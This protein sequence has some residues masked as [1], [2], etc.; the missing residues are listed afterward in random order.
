MT[1]SSYAQNYED[2]MLWRALNNVNNGFYVDLGSYDPIEHS[3]TKAF[4]DQGWNGINIE[5]VSQRLAKF[6]EER[7]R[8]INLEE[9][10]SDEVTDLDFY[11]MDNGGLSTAVKDIAAKHSEKGFIFS[12][13]KKKTRTLNN[14]LSQYARLKEIHFLK[15]DIEGFEFKALSGLDLTE[16]RPWIILVESVYPLSQEETYP[17]WEYLLIENHYSYIYADGLNR[18]YLANEKDNLSKFFK[19]PPNVFDDFIQIRI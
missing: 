6:R 4:Y 2:V 17:E 7:P 12:K 15:I 3:V 19:Y 11:I 1:F 8:D 18:F 9:L 10:V 13:T 14:I 16:F 5:P